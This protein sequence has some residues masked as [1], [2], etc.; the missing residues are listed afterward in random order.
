MKSERYKILDND[1]PDSRYK[2]IEDQDLPSYYPD[3]NFSGNKISRASG[4]LG[5]DISNIPN[6]IGKAIVGGLNAAPS[7]IEGYE[8]QLFTNPMRLLK[9]IKIGGKEAF[10]N[11]AEI[12]AAMAKY[13]AH[14][15]LIKPETAEKYQ[16]DTYPNKKEE[17]SSLGEPQPGDELSRGIPQFVPFIPQ[18]GKISSIGS[19]VAGIATSPI[20][21]AITG[22]NKY[23]ALADKLSIGSKQVKLNEAERLA[24]QAQNEHDIALLDEQ[25]N[26]EELKNVQQQSSEEVGKSN[27]SLMKYEIN[28][29]QNKQNLLN[30]NISG[31]TH[32]M[33]SIKPSTELKNSLPV[34]EMQYL[35]NIKDLKPFDNEHEK[36]YESS[37]S[38]R[39]KAEEHLSYAN[40]SH[41]FSLGLINEADQNIKNHLNPMGDYSVTTSRQINH[42]IQSIKNY[43]SNEYSGMMNDLKENNFELYNPNRVKRID[44]AV[45]NAKEYFGNDKNGEFSH[46]IELAPRSKDI[47]AADFMNRQKDFRDAMYDI[48]QRSRDSV[49]TP[50]ASDRSELRR[51]YQELLPFRSLVDETLR[52]GLGKHLPRYENI[53]EGYRTQ[54]YPLRENKVAQKIMNGTK[55]S[56]DIA[57][58]LSGYEE[59]QPLLREIANRNPEIQRNILGQQFSKNPD[60]V[61]NPDEKLREYTNNMP[62]LNHL[63]EMRRS[64]QEL[65]D[66]AYNNLSVAKNNHL[67]A[68][69][70]ENQ[71]K[72]NFN[73]TEKEHA[74]KMKDHQRNV[75]DRIKEKKIAEKDYQTKLHEREKENK[76]LESENLKVKENINK[77]QNRLQKELTSHYQEADII[78]KRISLLE[79]NV[80]DIQKNHDLAKNATVRKGITLDQKIKAENKVKQIKQ[81]LIKSQRELRNANFGYKNIINVAKKIAR[82]VP[83][84]GK[85]I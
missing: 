81:D 78:K 30:Q 28:N 73:E 29:L 68:I 2:I 48:S 22:S 25:K 70:R 26:Q 44:S 17:I 46:A 38:E 49:A 85:I 15:G 23:A 7:E 57:S 27:P 43:W 53:M 60:K 14:L 21:N 56:N 79:K 76:R 12:P 52:E 51:V 72:L 59:G 37:V 71:S 69:N 45:K 39:K 50:S 33:E 1:T 35:E 64:A 3:Q 61:I 5:N 67:N 24:E 47:N 10:S 63:I 34:P 19:R 58:E 66:R 65:K 16:Y 84:V 83:I 13:T 54:V 55:L 42:E 4:I 77:E 9:N 6:A 36:E 75:T 20:K 31:L 74:L 8:T 41:K 82:R 32:Q 40:D 62:H 11:F 18:I 80:S